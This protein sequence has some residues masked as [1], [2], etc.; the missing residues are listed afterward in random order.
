MTARPERPSHAKRNL[1]LLLTADAIML[2]VGLAACALPVRR[3]LRI[4]PT[5][6]LRAE[7]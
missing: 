4:D 2:V 3:A 1:A 7:G 6:A 5:E